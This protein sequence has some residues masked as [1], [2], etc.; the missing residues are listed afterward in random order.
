[1]TTTTTTRAREESAFDRCLAE[2][3][4]AREALDALPVDTTSADD[5]RIAMDAMCAAERRLFKQTP[6][7]IADVRAL[8]EVAFT[9]P[10]SIPGM[11]LIGAVL[12]G[13]RAFDPA[14]SR[15]FDPAKWVEQFREYGGG[16]VVRD[17]R[18][19]L[20]TPVPASDTLTTLMWELRTRG[21]EEQ[22]KSIIRD[23]DPAARIATGERERAKWEHIQRRYEIEA[24]RMAENEGRPYRGTLDDPECEK[25]EELTARIVEA[26]DAVAEELLRFPAPDAE[27][28]RFK[29]A[30]MACD[31]FGA[32]NNRHAPEFA[33][34]IA[35]DAAR[36]L[37]AEA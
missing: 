18:V 22:V 10:D 11:D 25:A 24:A 29:L 35:A 2:Y 30:L 1:M 3:L 31:H 9:D 6:Q 33:K 12:T 36:I 27:A 8:A 14:P 17:G 4:Q 7:N 32:F 20:L 15:V 16:W 34:I 23:L 5:E 19:D 21:G 26:Y 28:L 37:S 13:I